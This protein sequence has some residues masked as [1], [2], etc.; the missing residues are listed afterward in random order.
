MHSSQLTFTKHYQVGFLLN[1]TNE[2]IE[3]MAEFVG[4][5]PRAH[6]AFLSI[7]PKE[8]GTKRRTELSPMGWE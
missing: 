4:V 8:W 7:L 3:P 6:S 5:S 2:H 1:F